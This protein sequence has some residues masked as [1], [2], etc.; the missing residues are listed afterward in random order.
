MNAAVDKWLDDHQNELIKDLQECIKY[1]TLEGTPEEGKPFGPIVDA[2]LENTLS[3]A[4]RLGF[5]AWSLDGYYGIVEY[6]E[7][8]ETVGVLAH[9]DIVPVGDGWDFDPFAGVIND[10]KLY[11]RGTLDDKGPAIM[12]LYALA[13]LKE[14]A[15]A[16]KRK[17]RIILG[18]NEETGMR[19]VKYYVEKE[20]MPTM[21]FSPDAGYPVQKLCPARF[22]VLPE[23]MGDR[24]KRCRTFHDI[25]GGS[26]R[27]CP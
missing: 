6:G 4:R 9:L 3:L 13:A 10:G 22:P 19:C 1:N 27:H 15:V 24:R 16:L 21:S 5:K 11:G 2:C 18:C 14:T 7:G 17:I 23:H 25:S 20:G 26:Q 8:E 12:S